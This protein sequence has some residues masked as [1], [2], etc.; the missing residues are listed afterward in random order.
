MAE[1][2]KDEGEEKKG[3]KGKILAI[4]LGVVLVVVLAGGSAAGAVVLTLANAPA[5]AA[6]AAEEAAPAGEPRQMGPLMEVPALVVNL[7]DPDGSHFIRAGFQFELRDAEQQSVVESHLVPIRS[8]ILLHL[9]G[10]TVED[11]MGRENR[12]ALLER[13]LEL[14][15]E[16]I[17]SDLVTHI[18]FTA[19]VVQ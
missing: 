11:T 4:V 14:V 18:Y 8:A 15:N 5:P 7:D 6:A 1:D 17:G 19:L 2:K 9:S 13:M 3:G 10:L 12:E 16:Q